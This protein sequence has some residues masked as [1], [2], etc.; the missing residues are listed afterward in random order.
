MIHRM[1]GLDGEI[2]SDV[3]DEYRMDLLFYGF[4]APKVVRTLNTLNI[5]GRSFSSVVKLLDRLP[6]L[7]SQPSSNNTTR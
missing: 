3:R 1:C 6:A 2:L 4:I 5:F 7:Y